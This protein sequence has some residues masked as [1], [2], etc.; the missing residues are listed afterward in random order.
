LGYQRRIEINRLKIQ[1]KRLETEIN[2]LKAENKEL[3]ERLRVRVTRS[4]PVT[5]PAKAAISRLWPD[6]VP[7]RAKLRNV[8]L[9]KQVIDKMKDMQLKVP[10]GDIR[11]SILRAAGRKGR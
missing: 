2:R 3:R 1:I 6:G 10:D 5:G 8:E 9:I 4:S 11:Q 7:S